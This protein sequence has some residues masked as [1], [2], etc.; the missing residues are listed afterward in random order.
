MVSKG[1]GI[2]ALLLNIL[3]LPGLG[4]VIW[5]DRKTGIWQIVIALVSIPLM[6][7]LIGIITGAVAWIW[8]L[9]SGIHILK[10]AK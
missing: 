4:T 1:E 3:I 10:A 8:A 5:G 6:L 2:A 9:I 7:V